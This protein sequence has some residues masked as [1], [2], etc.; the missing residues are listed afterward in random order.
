MVKVFD[1][2]DKEDIKKFHK[3]Q[4]EIVAKE[5]T[6]VK[7]DVNKI[8]GMETEEEKKEREVEKLVAEEKVKNEQLEKEFEE[9]N[10][11]VK[12]AIRPIQ[13]FVIGRIEIPINVI[14]EVNEH[15]DNVIIPKND[16]FANG[17]VG[18][19]KNN[20]RSA[21]LDFPMDD[22][23]IGAQLKIVFDSVATTLLQRGYKRDAKADC[24][25]CWTNH[26]YAGDYNPYH[27]HGVQTL[28]GLSGFLWL[29]IP[30][31][32]E[33]TPDE[34]DT[35]T[36]ANGSVDGW[37]HLIWGTNTRKDI[38]QLKPQTEDYIKPE[39]GTML[40]FPNWLKHA[41]LPFFNDDEERRSM[42]MNWNVYD[43]EEQ[44]R[45]FLS[46]REEDQYNAKKEELENAKKEE[47]ETVEEEK[48]DTPIFVG[49]L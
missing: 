16:S 47:L 31:V 21:Q 23:G 7:S 17:L 29:K 49:N 35:L 42:A 13:D 5:N 39:V 6:D 8:F 1:L 34:P 36:N 19:L 48:R 15:I 9:K 12:F 2:D 22:D 33:C 37:T 43:S 32:I 11:G 30:R 41:V 20:E 44:Q 26:A 40:V 18:Q 10:A 46:P 28:A 25:Q 27:D 14:D 4:G 38:M 45:R 3:K 24:F